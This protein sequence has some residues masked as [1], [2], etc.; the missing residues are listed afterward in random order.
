MSVTY[1]TFNGEIVS[2]N[3]GGVIRYYVPDTNG[4]TAALM[5]ESGNVTDTYEYW[6]FGEIRSHV[7]PST[8]SFTFG[9]ILGCYSDSWG[10]IYMR[11]REFVPKLA[12]WLTVDPLWPMQLPYAYA[13][14]NP[15]TYA[16]PSGTSPCGG[17]GGGGS[18]CP[19]HQIDLC[20]QSCRSAGLDYVGCTITE[21]FG[22]L[23][24]YDCECRPKKCPS[25]PVSSQQA[26][27]NGLQEISRYY[28]K[29]R[30]SSSGP[31]NPSTSCEG[32]THQ[33]FVYWCVANSKVSMSINCCPCTLPG[34]G[35]SMT[36][37]YN[38]HRANR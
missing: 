9:G 13:F 23:E 4:N 24:T 26:K 7:G 1:T 25:P 10:G 30:L 29:C 27:I 22:F 35:E 18:L 14:N 31:V 5:D 33:T 37:T 36:C 15:V 8:T 12:R 38:A 34:G 20:K 21:L 19:P 6:P 17:G 28:Q 11:A 2:E 32:G 16:D 3:R